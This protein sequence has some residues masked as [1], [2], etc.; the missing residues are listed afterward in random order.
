MKSKTDDLPKILFKRFAREEFARKFLTGEI[1]FGSLRYFIDLEKSKNHSSGDKYEGGRVSDASGA[2]MSIQDPATGEWRPIKFINAEFFHSLNNV[3][4]YFISC[5]SHTICQQQEKYGDYL[6]TIIDPES[7][8]DRIQQRFKKPSHISF[9]RVIY[10][11]RLKADDPFSEIDDL[12]FL[13]EN[14][15]SSDFEFRLLI[16]PL[17]NEGKDVRFY[18]IGSIDDIAFLSFRGKRIS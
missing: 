12:C 4:Q 14:K 10:Y 8:Y 11:D 5:F 17:Q 3:D 13:K 2:T 7:L 1:R 9:K 16:G 15:H 18:N 6:V